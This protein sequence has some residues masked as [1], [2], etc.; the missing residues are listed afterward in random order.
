VFI[1]YL[2]RGAEPGGHL[3]DPRSGSLIA[4]GILTLVAG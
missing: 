1:R 2:S 4:A 3:G